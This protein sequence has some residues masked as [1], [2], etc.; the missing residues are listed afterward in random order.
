MK[1]RN[2]LLSR[3]DFKKEVF[4]RDNQSCVVCGE[5]GVDAHHIIERK[6]WDDGGYY[7]GNGAT[8]CS[9][10]HIKAEM[11]D[12]ST[13]E[14]W[15][16]VG[17]SI[18]LL[19][20]Y[21]DK[22]YTYD[23]WGNIILPHGA[24]IKGPLF[25]DDS[26]K[27]IMKDKLHLFTD[28]VKYPRTF[29]V[30]WSNVSDKSDKIIHSLDHLV[31]KN[32]V[33]TEKMDGENTSMYVNSIHARSLNWKYDQ[34]RSKVMQTWLRIRDDIPTGWRIC[35]ENLYTKHTVSYENLED[36]FLVFS[37]WDENNN[38]LS[39]EETLEWCELLDL[40]TVPVLYSGEFKLKILTDL[41]PNGKD[42]EG[43]V[44][45]KAETFKFMEFRQSVIK[46]VGKGFAVPDEHWRNQQLAVNKLK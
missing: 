31:G 4:A 38:C 39:W 6:L 11:T 10:C 22:C 45:R 41:K 36:Y 7:L 9:D 3:K 24:R 18:G 17:A 27:K 5:S 2:K 15:D 19:P 28:L 32:I 12:I 33:V 35:G 29:H 13:Q 30:P 40:K 16:A 21:F 8:V 34:T 23:K 25:H 43:W 26:V 42:S 14:L 20:P 44:V 46:Y 37:I 1:Q